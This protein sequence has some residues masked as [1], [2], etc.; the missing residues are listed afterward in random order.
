MHDLQQRG[1]LADGLHQATVLRV[2][3]ELT[4]DR[5]TIALQAVVDHHGA[6]RMEAEGDGDDMRLRVRQPATLR[7]DDI[8]RHVDV[9]ELDE[10]TMS[11][12]IRDEAADAASLLS[13]RAGAVLRVVWFDAGR[14]RQGR[15]L[16]V[17]HHL[18]VDG[19]SWQI[20]AADLAAAWEAL[21]AGRPPRLEPVATSFRSWSTALSE[22]AHD[23]ARVAELPIWQKILA[24][25]D[26]PPSRYEGAETVGVLQSVLPA[27]TTAGLASVSAAFHADLQDVLLTGL[28]LALART[29]CWT[30]GDGSNDESVFL[31][32]ERHG[33]E[34][35]LVPGADL[36]RT[37]G[38]FTSIHPVLLDPGP[39]DWAEILGPG[40]AVGN[41]LKRIKEQLRALP[42]H[43]IGY[44][45]LRHLNAETRP[46][47]AACPDPL[48]TFNYLGRAAAPS[49]EPW[50]VAED[51]F[52]RDVNTV[53]AN[54]LEIDAVVRDDGD[55][56]RLV[57]HWGWDR[58]SLSEGDISELAGTWFRLLEA[59][60]AAARL[61]GAG[62][63]T[64]SDLD[65]ITLTQ[66]DIDQLESEWGV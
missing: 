30:G 18:V 19:V 25:A 64:P 46:V 29:H 66:D 45:L 53:R 41:V 10:T 65:L 50:T 20:L 52:G 38:W 16:L 33:R 1:L 62:G 56:S 5:L 13:P 34:A 21:A 4:T 8:L 49:G 12:L 48:V 23:P 27:D 58:T 60:I 9:S 47:L 44:G 14:H 6:L 43:G 32:L 36:S 3:A 61:E 39:V 28:V 24:P 40:P 7:A 42:D 26:S 15:L 51:D 35:D 63:R 54:S 2:P 17:A 11:A 37:V 59:L 22:A 31:N 55:E 57:A